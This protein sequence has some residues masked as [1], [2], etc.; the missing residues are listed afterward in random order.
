MDGLNCN[1]DLTI[2]QSVFT[3]GTASICQGDSM[4]LHGC[5]N[6]LKVRTPS[7]Y[8][9]MPGFYFNHYVE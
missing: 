1:L 9:A 6:L 2:N 5:I 7:L 4:L 8:R 3:Q